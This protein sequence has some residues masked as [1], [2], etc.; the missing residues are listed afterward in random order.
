MCCWGLGIGSRQL[1]DE[2][3]Q[4]SLLLLRSM[5]HSHNFDINVCEFSYPLGLVFTGSKDCLLKVWDFQ[6]MKP[7]GVCIGH[8]AGA[9]VGRV[10]CSPV[11]TMPS[12]PAVAPAAA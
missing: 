5:A 7:T 12:R 1:Q 10:G 4:D 2:A 6:N 3:P 8:T 11:P 9:Q